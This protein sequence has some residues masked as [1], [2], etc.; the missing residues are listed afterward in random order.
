MKK[1]NKVAVAAIIT[2]IVI[3]IPVYVYIHQDTGTPGSIQIRG[4]VG[5][6]ENLTYTQIEAFSPV[7][8]QVN[9]KSDRPAE[10][11]TFN[12]TGVPLM[13]LLEQ[14]Q[15]SSNASSVY[16]LAPDGFAITLSIQDAQKAN[17]IIAYL[18]DGK[19]MSPLSDGGEGPMRLVIGEDQF[20]SRWVKDV[21]L[22]EVN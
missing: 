7:T 11:G 9:V 10:N 15:I 12:Y 17:T 3:T 22:I 18:K 8:V 14:A 2:L 20:A 19:S 5:H 6:P 21:S 1:A 13:F 16:I 4:A